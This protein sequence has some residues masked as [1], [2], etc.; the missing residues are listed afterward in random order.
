MV[1]K[2]YWK[3]SYVKE[4]SAVI[5]GAAVVDG[6]AVVRLDKTAFYPTG[7]GQPNDTGTLSGAGGTYNVTDVVKD[8]GDVLHVLDGGEN[9]KIGSS[10]LCSI[11]WHRRY[12]HMQYHTALHIIDGV[13]Y[14]SYKGRIT[15]GQIYED[16]ARMDFDV[17]GMDRVMAQRIVDDAQKVV[18]QGLAVAPRFLTREEA[19]AIPDLARTDPGSNLLSGLEEIRVI[20]IE[21]FDMQLDGGTHVANTNEI[22]RIMLDNYK[23]QGSHNKRV[24]ITLQ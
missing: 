4:F 8:G 2:I 7:G 1:E 9:L 15:G 13:V 6:K 5:T 12:A 14:K 22:G 10:V 23:N 16:R 21:G 20:D 17:P 24:T 11:N 18:D 3:D 19:A